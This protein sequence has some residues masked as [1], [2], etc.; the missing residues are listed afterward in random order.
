[1]WDEEGEHELVHGCEVV[2]S[3]EADYS[4]SKKCYNFLG[5]AAQAHAGARKLRGN[6]DD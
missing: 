2:E 5:E 4:I 6:T 1:M 3:L